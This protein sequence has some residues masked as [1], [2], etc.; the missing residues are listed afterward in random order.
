MSAISRAMPAV[1]VDAAFGEQQRP[2]QRVEPLQIALARERL[3]IALAGAARQLAHDDGGH[4][5]DEQRDPVLRVGDRPRSNRR[6]KEEVETEHGG[7]RGGRGLNDPPAARD[8]EHRQEI[9]ERDGCWIDREI[10]EVDGGDGP[11]IAAHGGGDSGAARDAWL[12]RRV[13]RRALT[14][15]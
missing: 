9:G 5:E 15:R 8:D 14:V 3:E 7:Q 11:A 12:C 13:T 10:A 6:K 1:A 4:H 2:A